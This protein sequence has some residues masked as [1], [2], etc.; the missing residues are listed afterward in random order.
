MLLGINATGISSMV[1]LEMST[2][3]GCDNEFAIV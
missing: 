3:T 1:P 2:R